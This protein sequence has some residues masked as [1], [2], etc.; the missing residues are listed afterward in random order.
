MRRHDSLRTGFA[1]VDERPVALSVAASKV[2]FTLAVE[3]LAGEARAGNQRARALLLKQAGLKAE[4]QAWTPFDLARA[5]LWRTVLFRLG[6]DDHVLLLILHHI[7]V[8]GWSIG[9]LF[10]EVSKLYSAIAAGQQAHLPRART[11]LCRF[12]A[13]ATPLVHERCR[14]PAA[15]LLEGALARGVAAV[16]KGY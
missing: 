15:G 9:L 5:P 14:D 6:P 13:L 12:R 7:I 10:D 11:A 2:D 1:W 16:S 3:D 4:Q 8:D